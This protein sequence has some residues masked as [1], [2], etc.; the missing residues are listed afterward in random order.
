ME[1]VAG[2]VDPRINLRRLVWVMSRDLDT[3]SCDG[4]AHDLGKISAADKNILCAQTDASQ[5]S[6]RVVANAE[7]TRSQLAVAASSEGYVV[8]SANLESAGHLI[9]VRAPCLKVG[10]RGV[11]TD[12]SAGLLVDVAVHVWSQP[13]C[14]S[15]VS[16]SK[17]ERAS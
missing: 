8:C 1:N 2:Y 4:V 7:A 15:L 9:P 3:A 5:M 11:L 17:L 14:V 13:S 16:Q 10:P 12:V 6:V